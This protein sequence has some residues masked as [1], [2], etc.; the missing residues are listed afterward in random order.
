MQAF[1]GGAGSRQPYGRWF[2]QVQRIQ[3][4][5]MPR[6]GTFPRSQRF[7]TGFDAAEGSQVP[8]EAVPT[9]VTHLDNFLIPRNEPR[10]WGKVRGRMFPRLLHP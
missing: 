1:W 9:I 5:L 2:L 8:G 10:R 4:N 7:R 6:G 3:G